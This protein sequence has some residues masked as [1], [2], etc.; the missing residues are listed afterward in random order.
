MNPEKASSFNIHPERTCSECCFFCR[1]KF[2][3]TETPLHILQMKSLEI[4][5]LASG[6]RKLRKD[7]CLCYKCFR[8]LDQEAKKFKRESEGEPEMSG[9]TKEAK[10]NP[11]NYEE[12]WNKKRFTKSQKLSHHIKMQKEKDRHVTISSGDTRGEYYFI[13]WLKRSTEYVLNLV[14]FWKS[15]LSS[16]Q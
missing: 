15:I 1:Q 8:L 3:L 16:L 7:A 10:N 13:I 11:T 14:N 2:G 12:G 4:Q 6:Y 9:D 5:K